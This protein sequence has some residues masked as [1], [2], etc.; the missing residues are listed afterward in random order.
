MNDNALLRVGDYRHG[1]FRFFA[2]FV[3]H[4]TKGVRR[5]FCQL[6]QRFIAV[7]NRLH[8]IGGIVLLVEIF[9]RLLHRITRFIA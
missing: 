1:D 8:Q 6:R 2:L 7:N 5:H 3:R 9:Q 4:A